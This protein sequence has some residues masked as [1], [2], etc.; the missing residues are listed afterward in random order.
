MKVGDTVTLRNGTMCKVV[1]ESQFGKFLLVEI[2][3][4]EEPPFTHWHNQD[5]SFYA[6]D[7]SPLDVVPY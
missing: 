2:T 7:E 6:D 4:T 3:E 1:Y 5:G